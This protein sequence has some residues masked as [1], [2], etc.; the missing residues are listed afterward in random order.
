MTRIHPRADMVTMA[1]SAYI[2][3]QHLK[4]S[5]GR[6]YLAPGRDLAQYNKAIATQ[7]LRN[8]YALCRPVA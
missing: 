5:Q 6:V 2:R 4:T 7:A 8:Q 3:G 1:L